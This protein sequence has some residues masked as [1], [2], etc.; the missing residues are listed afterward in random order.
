MTGFPDGAA[1]LN[2]DVAW[3]HGSHS[4]TDHTAAD[5]QFANRPNT[6]VVGAKRDAA[7][8]CPFDRPA[9]RLVR[10]AAGV[11][12]ARLPYRDDDDAGG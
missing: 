4:H 5:D 3:I 6:V 2:L 10:A 1:V 12:P 11:L 7:W 8:L 9:H